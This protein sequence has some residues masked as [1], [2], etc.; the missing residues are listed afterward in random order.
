MN[1]RKFAELMSSTD[2]ER[3]K[4]REALVRSQDEAIADHLARAYES[5]E[6]QS[7]ESFGKPLKDLPGY[8]E[9]PEEFRMSF[10]ILKNAAVTPPE[11]DLFH[12]RAA[13]RRALEL[14]TD[15][16]ERKALQQSLSEL[17]QLIALRL[18][19]MRMS[20]KIGGR[21]R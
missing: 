8:Q 6:L 14:A 16:A 18:E 10:K 2:V 12:K 13:L 9:T 5:G 15:E 11:I 3:R 21:L 19:A 1:I 7:A 17:E 4:K 20:G